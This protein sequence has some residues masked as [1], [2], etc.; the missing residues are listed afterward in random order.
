MLKKRATVDE[1]RTE[2]KRRIEACD[3]L[4]GHCR[5]CGVPEL[6]SMHLKEA[7]G[8]NWGIDALPHLAPGCFGAILKIVDQ[9]RLEFE[10]VP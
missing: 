6:R 10:L 8:P 7:D 4:D 3:D 1:I 9:A 5:G 2:L